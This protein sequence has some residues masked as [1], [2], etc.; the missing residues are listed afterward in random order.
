MSR[1]RLNSLTLKFINVYTARI[2]TSD[3]ARLKGEGMTGAISQMQMRYVA[4]EDRILFRVN[5]TDKQEFRFWLTRR[6]SLLL[7]NVLNKHRKSDVDVSTQVDSESKQAVRSFK[8]NQAIQAADF[9]QEFSEDAEMFPLGENIPLAFKL[10]YK[11]LGSDLHLGIHPK[12]GQGIDMVINEEVNPTLTQLILQAGQKGV[13][14]LK[15]PDI[16][17]IPANRVIN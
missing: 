15:K 6:Y 4:E 5:S 11:I 10:N 13:W 3:K 17:A 1:G 8:S 16:E 9:K 12:E 7:L 2:L 14:N